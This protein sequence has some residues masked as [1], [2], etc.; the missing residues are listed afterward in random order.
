MTP[1]I[2]L[3]ILSAAYRRAVLRGD[4]AAA[5]TIAADIRQIRRAILE[6]GPNQ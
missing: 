2:R 1:L 3:E 6:Q 5:K 4:R